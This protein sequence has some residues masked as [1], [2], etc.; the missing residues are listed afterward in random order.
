MNNNDKSKNGNS[1]NQPNERIPVPPLGR[2]RFDP[3]APFHPSNDAASC[4]SFDSAIDQLKQLQ[5]RPNTFP[6]AKQA[7]QESIN[8]VQFLKASLGC[9]STGR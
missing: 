7:L 4:A 3:I 6:A 5:Q 1:K 9:R 8:L 2:R